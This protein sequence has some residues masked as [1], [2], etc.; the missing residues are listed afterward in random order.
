[1]FKCLRTD[2][3]KHLF[4]ESVRSFLSRSPPAILQL[5]VYFSTSVC[6]Q[7]LVMATVRSYNTLSV[8]AEP[9]P[10]SCRCSRRAPCPC[11]TSFPPFEE[12]KCLR[13]LKRSSSSFWHPPHPP[14]LRLPPSAPPCS[15]SRT[16]KD[17]LPSEIRM[18]PGDT[19]RLCPL[20]RPWRPPC[21]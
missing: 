13:S 11:L 12:Y 15:L 1:M 8:M 3:R 19:T 2:S 18:I 20:S 5:V 7:R 14:P 16:A 17:I 9:L 10:R 4:L 21:G 6:P